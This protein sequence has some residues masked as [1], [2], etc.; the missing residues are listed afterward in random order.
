MTDERIIPLSA[1]D[2]EGKSRFVSILRPF[3][4]VIDLG[5]FEVQ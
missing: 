4:R 5:A 1:T 3:P 2:L